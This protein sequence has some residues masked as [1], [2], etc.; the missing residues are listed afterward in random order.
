MGVAPSGGANRCGGEDR[1]PG[2]GAGAAPGRSGDR[3]PGAFSAGGTAAPE[4][5]VTVAGFRRLRAETAVPSP[6]G[7]AL[8]VRMPTSRPLLRPRASVR[9]SSD[10]ADGSAAF[11]PEGGRPAPAA[12]ALDSTADLLARIRTG[13]PAARDRLLA[14]YLPALHRWARGRLPAFARDR[15]DTDDLVQVTLLRTLNHLETFVPEREGAFLAYLRRVLQNQIR[16]E[17]RRVRRR[18]ARS[19]LDENLADPEASPLER[20]VGREV[21]ERYERALAR[22]SDE[23]QEAIVLRVEMGFS[24]GQIAE[25]TGRPTENAARMFVVRALARLAEEID[26]RRDG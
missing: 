8:P 12:P 10:H 18:P 23:Q 19:E 22:L 14:R 9:R 4:D 15:Y 2:P 26:E 25:A 5:S 24:Y 7:P 1:E 16:D 11:G 3:R 13:D 21:L 6:S 20:A 17:I